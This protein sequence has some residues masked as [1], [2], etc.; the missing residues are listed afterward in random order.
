[1]IEPTAPSAAEP[2][3]EQ[4]RRSVIV[5]GAGFVGLSSALWLQRYGHSVVVVDENPPLE[6]TDYR[7]ACSYGNA[8]CIALNAC[9][10]V[11][12]PGIV[13]QLPRM[14]A[15]RTSPL[16]ISWRDLPELL[17]WMVHFLRASSAAS[18]ERATSI[19]GQLIRLAESGHALLM[20]ECGIA[21]L[22]RPAGTLHLFHDDNTFQSAL[23]GVRRREKEGV[24]FE[25]LD[26]AAIRERE[27]N[28]APCY[29]RGV[30]YHDSYS[31]DDPHAYAVGL[32][33]AFIARGGRFVTGNARDLVRRNEGMEIAVDGDSYASDR[34]VIAAGAWSARLAAM[35]GDHVPLDTERGYHVLFPGGEKLLST[36]SMYPEHGFYMTPLSEGLRA[37][38]TVELG[39]L[40]RPLRPGRCAVIAQK[41]RRFLPGLGEHTREWRGFRPSMPDSL[42][43]IGASPHDPRV[44]YA[45]GHGHVG[46]T[47]AGITGR[48]VADIISGR[49]APVDITPLRPDRFE[50]VKRF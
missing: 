44:V 13:R 39:G 38:G 8:G 37:A 41:T 2:L 32:G 30:L 26:A 11:A 40:D 50:R 31:I 48:I 6:G 21:A 36:P 15:D 4:L 17:P 33:K 14:L 20:A 43:V 47:L 18:A 27:P 19:L 3:P 45:F 42:P 12:G 7:R 28:L 29:H 25:L 23:P 5:V 49:Q 24:R 34:L 1:M 35:V 10:P 9:L 22:K 16:S 46:L